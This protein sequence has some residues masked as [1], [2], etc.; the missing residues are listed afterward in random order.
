[1]KLRDYKH[2]IV[3]ILREMY[4]EIEKKRSTVKFRRYLLDCATRC[5]KALSKSEIKEFLERVGGK[6]G[7][8]LRQRMKEITSDHKKRSEHWDNE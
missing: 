7:Y 1:M 2:Y 6:F 8:Q 4:D 3:G 5:E